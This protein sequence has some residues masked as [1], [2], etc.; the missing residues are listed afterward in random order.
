M[1]IQAGV[2]QSSKKDP[3]ETGFEACKLALEKLGEKK[4]DLVIVFSSVALDQKEVI[5]GVREASGDVLLVGCS[6]AGSITNA[7]PAENAVG[8]MAI[9]S[10]KLN[11]YTGLKEGIKDGAREAG[12][13]VAKEIQENAKEPLKVF[14]HPKPM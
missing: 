11:F 7:G 12:Q 8:V 13:S 2:G 4:A 6:D 14:L 9:S 3:F 10:D 5:R 1:A